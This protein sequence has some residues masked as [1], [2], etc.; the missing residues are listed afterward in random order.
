MLRLSRSEIISV[1]MNA[2]R[3]TFMKSLSKGERACHP[4][5]LT[6]HAD[7]IVLKMKCKGVPEITVIRS[8]SK[9]API[10][11]TSTE[12][13][14]SLSNARERQ[15]SKIVELETAEDIKKF[16]NVV[17]PQPAISPVTAPKYKIVYQNHVDMQNYTNARDSPTAL[18]APSHIL[19]TFWLPLVV[20]LPSH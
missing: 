7:F 18:S 1:G 14:N 4:P 15:E 8:K 17:E 16:C 20:L 12:F 5:P 19:L 13:L 6:H 11:S 10:S 2:V 9:S 3:E